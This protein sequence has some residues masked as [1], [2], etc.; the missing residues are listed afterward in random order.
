[1]RPLQFVENMSR[2][3]GMP[4]EDLIRLGSE[5]TL[6]ERKKGYLL[7]RLEILARYGV[8]SSQELEERIQRG[9]VPDHPAWED[10][11]EVKNLDAEVR[12]IDRDLG[13]VQAA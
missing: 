7:E 9:E 11:I 13:A 3:Y 8:A 1:M 6:K 4:V 5:L 12:E 2:K 10:L